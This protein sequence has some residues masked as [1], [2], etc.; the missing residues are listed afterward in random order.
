M[1]VSVSEQEFVHGKG[2]IKSRNVKKFLFQVF[3]LR[4]EDHEAH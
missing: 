3:V 4:D 2:E 1:F